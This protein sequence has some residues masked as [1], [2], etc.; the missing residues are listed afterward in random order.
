VSGLGVGHGRSQ[1]PARRPTTNSTGACHDRSMA[2]TSTYPARSSLSTATPGAN[3][4]P[5]E[6]TTRNAVRWAARRPGGAAKAPNS[7]QPPGRSAAWARSIAT[8]MTASGKNGPASHTASK[9]SRS[10]RSSTAIGRRSIR[11][12]KPAADISCS[13]PGGGPPVSAW[14]CSLRTTADVAPGSTIVPASPLESRRQSAVVAPATVVRVTTEDDVVLPE[15]V[16][17]VEVP[18]EL[19]VPGPVLGFEHAPSA[20]AAAAAAAA[21]APRRRNSR[22]STSG[23]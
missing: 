12:L 17:G 7:S 2:R 6:R 14:D 1:A 13:P 8:G 4:V 18:G 15:T 19:L 11:S 20:A 22:R 5:P 23:N 10:R 16:V 21:P 3:G 9:A